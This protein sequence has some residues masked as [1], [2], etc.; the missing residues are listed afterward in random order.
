M[1]KYN[2]LKQLKNIEEI[3]NFTRT[4]VLEDINL[5]NLD[6]NKHILL[7]IIPN[8]IITG[9]LKSVSDRIIEILVDGNVAPTSFNSTDLI[10][11]KVIDN[12]IEFDT[13]LLNKEVEL[14]DYNNVTITAY[15]NNYNKNNIDIECLYN[16]ESVKAT[17]PLPLIKSIKKIIL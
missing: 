16:N 10:N 13:T 2:N 9:T 11:Y 12:S 4:E 5:M 7:V 17:I 3:E 14:T 1:K 8:V 15:I 6:I